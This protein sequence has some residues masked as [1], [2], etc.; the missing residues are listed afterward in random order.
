MSSRQERVDRYAKAVWEVILDRWTS[1]LGEA[2]SKVSSDKK[3]A[4]LLAD[5]GKPAADRAAALEKALGKNVPVEVLNLLKLMAEN[6]DIGLIDEV[7]GRLGQIVTG[8]AIS[9]KAE[10]TS[11]IALSDDEK[12]QIRKRLIAEH[13]EGLSF[14]FDVDPALLGGLR[15]R[16][17]D[18]LIDN[19]VA[20]R[21]ATLR[22]SL[23]SVVR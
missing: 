15:V 9:R 11:A 18:R 8:Q 17:G 19:S 10:V 2:S 22:E 20:S 21:L 12:E 5:T 1:A 4:A 14:S 6:D 13:G 3:L 7:A 23:S 16:V